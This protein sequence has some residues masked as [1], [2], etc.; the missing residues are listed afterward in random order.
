MQG[1]G[2]F[3]KQAL[4]HIASPDQLD[5]VITI[6]DP[7]GWLAITALGLIA[8]AIVIWSILGEVP[9]TVSG[10]GVIRPST[11]LPAVVA[12]VSG[13][14]VSLDV[15]RTLRVEAGQVL[16]SIQGATGDPVQVRAPVG[17]TVVSVG[18]DRWSPVTAGAVIAE[19]EP[20]DA[21][22]V[23]IL[24]VPAEQAASIRPGMKV[25][26]TPANRTA[27]ATG[28][29]LGQVAER[30]SLPASQSEVASI[31]GSSQAAAELARQI[32]EPLR[33][34]VT[35]DR[36][37]GR[38]V[39]TSGAGNDGLILPGIALSGSVVLTQ[40]PPIAVVIPALGPQGLE[41]Q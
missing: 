2:L 34:V 16:G 10:Q 3:R 7:R 39:W 29:I 13:Q 33:V 9:V 32:P 23:A 1:E 22:L 5:Q 28:F 4:R 18:V 26:L 6:T 27:N 30:G 14:V 20:D 24:F 21:V 19:I 12:P 41:P 37:D 11:G 31:L 35:L 38:L 40:V 36:E 25:Q 17:G 8:G 15:N